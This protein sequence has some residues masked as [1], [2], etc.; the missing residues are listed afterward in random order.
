VEAEQDVT[1]FDRQGCG[2]RTAWA[3]LE[4]VRAKPV[5]ELLYIHDLLE[6]CAM[7]ANLLGS[8]R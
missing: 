7:G 4:L 8:M 1:I 5:S 6:C 3:G 2:L